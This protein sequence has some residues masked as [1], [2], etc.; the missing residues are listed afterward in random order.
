[1]VNNPWY[2]YSQISLDLDSYIV[3]VP[4]RKDSPG[5]CFQINATILNHGNCQRKT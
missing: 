1:M 3:F 4:Y 2:E 5:L